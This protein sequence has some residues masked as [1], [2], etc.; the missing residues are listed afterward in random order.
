MQILWEFLKFY[1]PN[2]TALQHLFLITSS[3]KTNCEYDEDLLIS[4]F[5]IAQA[6]KVCFEV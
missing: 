3:F 1:T 4:S 6:K 5:S 2:I